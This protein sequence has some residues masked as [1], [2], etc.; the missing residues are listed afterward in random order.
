M[1]VASNTKLPFPKLQVLDVSHNAFIGSLPERYLNNLRGMIDAK[2]NQTDDGENLFLK[3]I[4]LRLTLK[5]L[6]QLLQRLLNT[7]TTIDLSSNK[8]SGTIPP[9]IA[10]LTS[11]RYLNLSH[12][13][14]GGHIP[15]SLGDM[16]ILESL[17]LSSNKLDGEIPRELAKLTFLA[18]LNL[19]MNNLKG[20]IPQFGQLSTFEN[21]SYAG[22]VGLCGFPLTRKCEGG[23]GKWKPS[24]LHVEVESDVEVEWIY[25]FIA[26]GY[27]VSI[28]I[29]SWLL[30]FWR[31][32]RYKYYE[33]VD[34]VLE[35][36]FDFCQCRKKR[37]RRRRTVRNLAR[38][39][40]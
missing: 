22:N 30:L 24:P 33:I 10:N 1:L 18:K 7:F 14:I 27:V 23:D 11:I 34:Y 9:S 19:S 37:E 21:N 2:E 35:K 12:N 32:F 40:S 8:F 15:A 38:R 25:V 3:Y 39:Q 13:T 17:D 4:K 20:K 5:G 36:I 31:S 28:G 26:L 16:S 6:D 29:F